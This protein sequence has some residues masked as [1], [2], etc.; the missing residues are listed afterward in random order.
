MPLTKN[1]LLQIN[2]T[3]ITGLLILFTIQS[4]STNSLLDIFYEH[5]VLQAED[6]ILSDLQGNLTESKKMYDN[7]DENGRVILDTKPTVIQGEITFSIP[8]PLEILE[9]QE[10]RIQEIRDANFIDRVRLQAQID[11]LDDLN[12]TLYLYSNPQFVVSLLILPFIISMIFEL[13]S[14]MRN[15]N[16]DYPNPWSSIAFI[17]GLGVMFGLFGLIFVIHIFTTR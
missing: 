5:E 3:I 4:V 12:L 2:A 16:N 1:N 9:R 10:L 7:I 14:W 17:I 11:I 6:K 13:F 15:M 8:P